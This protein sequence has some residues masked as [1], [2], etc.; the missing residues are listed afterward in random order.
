MPAPPITTEEVLL[1]RKA[2][3]R[4]G[5]DRAALLGRVFGRPVRS[6]KALR[7]WHD[8]LLFLLAHPA[9]AEEHR[10]ASKELERLSGL[11]KQMVGSSE[12]LRYALINSGIDGA[13]LQSTYS[14][15]LVRWMLARWEHRVELFLVEAGLDE[16]RELLRLLLP[17]VE[18]ETVDQPFDDAYQLLETVYGASRHTQLLRLVQSLDALGCD[19][20]QRELLFA[21]MQVYVKVEGVAE[22]CGTTFARGPKGPVFHQATGLQRGV[23]LTATLND[24]LPKPVRLSVAE[25]H[26]LIDT[27]RTVLAMLHRETDPVTH[28]G[29][30]ELFDMGRGLRIALF[31][32][33]MAHRLPFD[34]YVGFMAFK[35][36]VPLAYG[37]AWIF[38]GRSKVGINIFA[39]LRGGESAWFFAQL[40]RLYR[41]RY[42]VDRFEAEN[43]QLGHHNPD[44]LNSGAYWFYYRLGFRPVGRKDQL[45]AAREFRKLGAGKG[46]RVPLTVLK[47]LVEHGLELVIS[48]GA[49]AV[50][51]TAA[52]TM[53]VQ[54]H[55][56]ER[57]AGDHSAAMEQAIARLHRL[58][59][60]GNTGTWTTEERAALSLW[61]LALDMIDELG[62]LPPNALRS[63][64][65]LVRAKGAATEREHQQR[66]MR[67]HA[68]LKAFALKARA[69]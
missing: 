61:A 23:D 2:L 9:N 21:R 34:S 11:A 5:D 30:V 36:G 68:L 27:A 57:Y 51:D 62:D 58:L 42:G 38:P 14:L 22:G 65:A 32:L 46:Y 55:V 60:L 1:L 44:G 48:E 28:A 40:L 16:L 13:P 43:Y 33:D 37:G 41:Q 26:E 4:A 47:H 52:L 15:R 7:E 35:N 67:H 25:Q 8:L 64:V 49:L 10:L 50:M 69:M 19:D 66:L 63:L 12:A 53:A 6:P 39:A 3:S 18:H 45:I 59:P 31:S 20:R 24:P 17:P 54:R 56:V 29:A